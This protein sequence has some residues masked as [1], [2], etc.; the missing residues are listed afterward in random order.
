M[1]SSVAVDRLAALAQ[2][3]RLETF[4]LLVRHE[5]DGLPAGEIARRVG[6]P[7]NTMSSH[8][9]ILVHAGLAQSE[10]RGRSIVYRAD[11]ERFRELVSFMVSDCCGGRPDICGMLIA[12]LAPSC[13][14]VADTED[15]RR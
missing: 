2:S 4:Q 14:A 13:A 8:L 3:T 15:A 11:L 10:R 12:D 5:P 6:A 7:Q 9:A 1:E